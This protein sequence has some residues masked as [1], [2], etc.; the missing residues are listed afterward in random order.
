M[1]GIATADVSSLFFFNY[2]LKKYVSA[3]ILTTTKKTRWIFF[4]GGSTR[5]WAFYTSSP[6]MSPVCRGCHS[7]MSSASSSARNYKFA[8]T[9][10][11]KNTKSYL[12]LFHENEA[13]SIDVQHMEYVKAHQ[14]E[15]KVKIHKL[16]G[17]DIIGT[18]NIKRLFFCC[19]CFSFLQNNNP[20]LEHYLYSTHA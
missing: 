14:D 2:S 11:P 7:S 15:Q 19:W 5:S 13:S 12:R 17:R 9:T 20:Q 18:T 6:S 16:I 4:L 1:F 10:K 3:H 8:T